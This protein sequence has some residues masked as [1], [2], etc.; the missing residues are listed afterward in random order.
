MNSNQ[1]RDAISL[2]Y[3][4]QPTNLPSICDA[5][6]EGFTVCH[7]LNCKKGGLVTFRHN[8]LR[9]LNIEL[10]K[11][12]GFTQTVK[13]PIVKETDKNGE[14]G[15]RAD[16][17]VRGFWEHQ[18]EALFDCR[19]FNADAISYVNTPITTLLENQR[20][21]KKKQYN[22]AVEDRRGTFTPFIATCDAILD[23]EAEHYIKRSSS[24]LSEK[25]GKCYSVVIGWVR[26]RIQVCILRS[27]SLCLRGSRTKWMSCMIED[28]S[29]MPSLENC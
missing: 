4:K 26:A 8:E 17:S 25:W 27:V 9:D 7:A 20:N 14:G 6:G 21:E 18:R 28:G 22:N 15:L 12:A 29:A 23:V 13:E 10:V 19:I 16:W 11:S 2:R 5:D 24:Y 1:F 3:G